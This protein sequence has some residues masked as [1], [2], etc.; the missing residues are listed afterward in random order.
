MAKTHYEELLKRHGYC[1]GLS[2]MNED[3]ELVIVSI[4]HERAVIKTSQHNG[5]IRTNI[6]HKDGT[7]EEL[8]DH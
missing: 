2:G 8:F 6:Y 4:D 3:G 1:E 7:S 5:W